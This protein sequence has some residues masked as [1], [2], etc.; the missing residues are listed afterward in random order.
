MICDFSN[1]H[2]TFSISDPNTGRHHFHHGADSFQITFDTI[3][4]VHAGY[5]VTY[6]ERFPDAKGAMVYDYFEVMR[7]IPD[8]RDILN[9]KGKGAIVSAKLLQDGTGMVISEPL[10]PS[11]MWQNLP[12]MNDGEEFSKE[13]K[14]DYLEKVKLY[15]ESGEKTRQTTIYFP[16]GV[17]GSTEYI[18]AD[19][20]STERGTDLALFDNMFYVPIPSVTDEDDAEVLCYYG[21]WKIGVKGS[22]KKLKWNSVADVD[23][24]VSRMVKLRLT[25]KKGESKTE[26][27]ENMNDVDVGDHY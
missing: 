11:Y 4:Q 12:E 21:Y 6:V 8:G 22:T 10:L 15:K 18:G 7:Y 14:I 19:P 24:T 2:Y 16:D 23:S 25:K 9:L 27:D 17:I 1:I 20:D 5:G 3:H 26:L 13:K